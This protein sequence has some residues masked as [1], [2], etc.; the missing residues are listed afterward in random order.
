MTITS[1]VASDVV[2]SRL[3]QRGSGE[4]LNQWRHRAN[5]VSFS[6]LPDAK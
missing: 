2:V 3:S 1:R 6:D 4:G 5:Y